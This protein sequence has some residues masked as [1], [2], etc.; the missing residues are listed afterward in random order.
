LFPGPWYRVGVLGGALG[1]LD[2]GALIVL[3]GSL[4][5]PD[6]FTIGYRIAVSIGFGAATALGT[7]LWTQFERRR[8]ENSDAGTQA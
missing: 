7:W 5:V 8:K 6:K 4:G 3:S 2:A 1:L